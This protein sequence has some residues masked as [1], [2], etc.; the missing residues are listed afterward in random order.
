MAQR[1]DRAAW[2]EIFLAAIGSPDPYGRQLDGMGGGI[3][4]LS[5]VVVIAPSSRADADIDYTFGQVVI[6]RPFVDYGANCG[7]MSS[8]VGPFSVDEGLVA[9]ASGTARI[10]IY[11]TNTAKT[12]ISEFPVAKGRAVVNGDYRLLGVAGA[13]AKIRL[14][15]EDPGGAVTGKLL[16]TGNIRDVLD[17]PGMGALE[18]SMVDATNAG[19][20]VDA[21]ALG[22]RGTELPDE[23]AANPELL[24]RLEAI[25]GAAAVAMGLAETAAAATS[26]SP[27]NPKIAVVSPPQPAST[28]A[29]DV[30][31][32]AAMD[33]T[34]RMISV[35]QPHRAVPLTGAM[36][37]SVAARIEGTV[38]NQAMRGAQAGDVRI[39]HPS[40]IIDLAAEVSNAGGWHAE[41]V[42][43]YR[44][45]RR[46]MEGAV[47]IPSRR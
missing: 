5:K 43:V 18:V 4:S 15:F 42:V 44:T 3:S 39:A 30:L 10:R 32:P 7:N 13:G 38:V 16:P 19:V 34:A 6:D 21:A 9:V 46:L 27:S 45:A 47:L 28:L 8:A 31:D 26:A 12:I 35:G 36:C 20:F 41:R 2:D 24:N 1:E 37:L 14:A 33:F 23:L 40:G 25:R 22:L 11:N 17:I 29:G